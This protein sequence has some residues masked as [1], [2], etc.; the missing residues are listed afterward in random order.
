MSRCILAKSGSSGMTKLCR[1]DDAVISYAQELFDV[2]AD[3]AS[4]IV[5]ADSVDD[6]GQ[7]FLRIAVAALVV[8]VVRG[9]HHLVDADLVDQLQSERVDDERRAHVVVPVVANIV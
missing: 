6:G 7:R 2:P 3:D 5:G 1:P 8:R 9:P 4:R